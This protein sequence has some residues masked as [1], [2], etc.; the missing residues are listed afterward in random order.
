MKLPRFLKEFGQ[1]SSF[2]FLK[3]EYFQK[4]LPHFE[5]N[6]HEIGK[7]FQRILG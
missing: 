1:I 6:N 4:Q 7:V 3:S 2:L 5:E